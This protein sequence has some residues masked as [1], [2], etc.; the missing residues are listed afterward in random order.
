M[1]LRQSGWLN[2]YLK[3]FHTDNA[4]TLLK[5]RGTIRCCFNVNGFGRVLLKTSL[6]MNELHRDS[7]HKHRECCCDTHG[8]TA[9][10]VV[11]SRVNTHIDYTYVKFL[12]LIKLLLLRSRRARKVASLRPAH[13]QST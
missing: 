2:N 7:S 13:G 4:A 8:V 3:S 6:H 10:V 1:R 11:R 9:S 5:Y 12:N